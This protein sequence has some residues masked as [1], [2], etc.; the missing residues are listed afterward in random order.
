MSDRHRLTRRTADR[1][2]DAPTAGEP[3]AGVLRAASAAPASGPLP[4]EETAVA[5]FRATAPLGPVADLGGSSLM[6]RT[7]RKILAVPAA[8]LA[9]AGVLVA[10]GGV[11]LAAS[12]GALHVPFTGHDNRS[13]KAPDAPA[14][15]NPGLTAS[16]G[17]ETDSPGAQPTGV[18][19]ATPSPSLDGLCHA[20][21]AGAVEKAA[22]N[23][24]FAALTAAAGGEDDVAAYCVDRI[25]APRTHPAKPTQAASP[26][27][28][29]KPSQAA[30]P[31]KPAKPSQAA[32][33]TRP[34]LPER[35][36]TPTKPDQAQ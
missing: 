24:A 5:R 19:S 1:L 25:G 4:G 26:T 16:H 12:Q 36:A 22:D 28:P 2:L 32:T 14:P 11:A 9:A 17:P 15:Q 34:A 31:A 30:T 18:P 20:F 6:S 7:F 23:P 8:G 10:G 33:P 13:P 27:Q 21:Q 35:A 29:A 3:V